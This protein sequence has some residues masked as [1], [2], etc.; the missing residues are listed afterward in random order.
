MRPTHPSL[1][2]SETFRILCQGRWRPKQVLAQYHSQPYQL[3]SPH[4]AR[5]V[6]YWQA[7]LAR[8]EQHL[9]NGALFRLENFAASTEQLQLMLGHT[10][11]RDQIYCNAHTS[12]LVQAH[13]ANVLA[14]GLGVSA[15]V[16]TSDGYLPLMRRG[17]CVGEEPGK[18]DV[19]GGHAHPDQHL[20]EGKPDLFAAIAEE[21]VAEL[22]VA[23]DDITRNTCCGL[24][25]NLLTHKPDLVFEI[26]LRTS[27]EEI[28]AVAAHAPE[29]EEVAELLFLPNETAALQNFLAAHRFALTPSALGTLALFAAMRSR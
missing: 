7:L 23:A 9:F 13:G 15:V 19:F 4:K 11:Y 10:C 12:A 2:M 18:L 29:A 20:R 17:E 5:A 6:S 27:R 28:A 24:V 21:I 8:D 22:N 14:C 25:E 16:M 26:A 3:P 1:T